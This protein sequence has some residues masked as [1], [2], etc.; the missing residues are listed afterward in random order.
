[1]ETGPNFMNDKDQKTIAG[2]THRLMTADL[3]EETD[4]SFNHFGEGCWWLTTL[5]LAYQLCY[6][7]LRQFVGT[8]SYSSA[9][10]I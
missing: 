10:A 7:A 4:T 2:K 9:M 5:V 6:I 1:M 3:Y 8:F